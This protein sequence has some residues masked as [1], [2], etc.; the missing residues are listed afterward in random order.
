MFYEEP[1]L[2]DFNRL[3]E[4]LELIK[5]I[6]QNTKMCV[7]KRR[8]IVDETGPMQT[9]RRGLHRDSRKKTLVWLTNV[10]EDS[11]KYVIL[12]CD[13]DGETKEDDAEWESRYSGIYSKDQALTCVMKALTDS[14]IGLESLQETYKEDIGIYVKYTCLLNRLSRITDRGSRNI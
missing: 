14:T 3:L 13:I 9:I 2:P 8:L 12:L 7:R 11:E 1:K 10:Y 4:N 6:P 5:N